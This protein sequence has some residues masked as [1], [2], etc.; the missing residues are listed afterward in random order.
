MAHCDV[1]A[2]KKD[3]ADVLRAADVTICDECVET[4]SDLVAGKRAARD[5]DANGG[6]PLDDL[7]KELG[8]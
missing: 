8:H 6:T 4:L 1:C 3:E 5:F 7:K 2:E